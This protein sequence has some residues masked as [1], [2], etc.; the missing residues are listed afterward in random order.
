M[1]RVPSITREVSCTGCSDTRVPVDVSSTP[2][3]DYVVTPKEAYGYLSHTDHNRTGLYGSHGSADH[4]HAMCTEQP[5]P[6][7]YLMRNLY[8]LT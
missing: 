8:R 1:I 4:Y 7:D 6:I 3:S 5:G 2:D